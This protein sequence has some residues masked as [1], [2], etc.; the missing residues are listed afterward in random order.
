MMRADYQAFL[1][2]DILT[3][4]DWASMHVSLE[5]RDPML[6]HRIAEFAFTLPLEYLYGPGPGGRPTHCRQRKE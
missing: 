6:E 4:V 2:D 3:K 5:A 1:R